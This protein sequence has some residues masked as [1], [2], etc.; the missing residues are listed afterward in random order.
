MVSCD[1]GKPEDVQRAFKDSWAVFAV[2]DF[3]A[4]PHQPEVEIQQGQAM[5]DAAATLQIP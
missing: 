2:T 5:S 4:Q 1:I 3:W